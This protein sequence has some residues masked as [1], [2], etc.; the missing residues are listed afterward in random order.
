[1]ISSKCINLNQEIVQMHFLESN[2]M[3]QPYKLILRDPPYED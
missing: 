3:L 1:M 2:F